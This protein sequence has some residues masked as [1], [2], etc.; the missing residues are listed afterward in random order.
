MN[1]F[2]EEAADLMVIMVGVLEVQDG[3]DN[4]KAVFEKWG[5]RWPILAGQIMPL[6]W[7]DQFNERYYTSSTSEKSE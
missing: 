4:L 2:D 1:D 7:H 6:L 3:I 5:F